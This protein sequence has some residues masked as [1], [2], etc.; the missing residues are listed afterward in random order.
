M[1]EKQ[2]ASLSLWHNLLHSDVTN[3]TL[4]ELSGRGS[5]RKGVRQVR[6]R[7][8]ESTIADSIQQV[9]IHLSTARIDVSER[10]SLEGVTE[11]EGSLAKFVSKWFKVDLT[12]VET[13]SDLTV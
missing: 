11:G 2:K 3:D 7:N 13:H 10:D 5:I 12:S 4:G 9:A 6:S 1:F 8:D